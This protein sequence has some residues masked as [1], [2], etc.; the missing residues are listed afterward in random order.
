MNFITRKSIV[1]NEVLKVYDDYKDKGLLSVYWHGSGI[2]DIDFNETSD[3]DLFGIVDNDFS[4]DDEKVIFD[5]LEK[6]ENLDIN[7]RA[8]YFD[9]LNGVVD[10]PIT[11]LNTFLPAKLLLMNFEKYILLAGKRFSKDDFIL[12]EA[13]FEEAVNIHINKYKR[14]VEEFNVGNK[15]EMY[16]I[17][18]AI[19]YFYYKS[20]LMYN[21]EFDFS[22]QNL[23]EYVCQEFKDIVERLVFIK[24]NGYDVDDVKEIILELDKLII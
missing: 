19:Y 17:K 22:Y 15:W 23:S 24:D 3:I 1:E 8:I 21:R 18:S 11:Y 20:E 14:A 16:V 6:Y 10:K 9:E 5:R 7:F 2:S 13:T 12:N 4:L